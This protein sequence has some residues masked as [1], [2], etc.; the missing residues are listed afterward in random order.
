MGWNLSSIV[1]KDYR[2]NGHGGEEGL[3]STPS[4]NKRLCILA[5]TGSFNRPEGG[6]RLGRVHPGT[7]GADRFD[8]LEGHVGPPEPVVNSNPPLGRP[9]PTTPEWSEGPRDPDPYHFN[10]VWRVYLTFH[11]T[12]NP[13]LHSPPPNI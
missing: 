10:R 3:S 9:H 1:Q 12:F 8:N 2:V 4:P 5:E 13:Q 11:F 7:F 6:I